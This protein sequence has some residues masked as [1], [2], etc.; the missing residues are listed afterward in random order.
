[1]NPKQDS[2]VRA[3]ATRY[4]AWAEAEL[5]RTEALVEFPEELDHSVHREDWRAEMDAHFARRKVW[6]DRPEVRAIR[7][8]REQLYSF[9]A[10]CRH[11]RKHPIARL[12]AQTRA[13]GRVEHGEYG[14]PDARFSW[15]W[16]DLSDDLIQRPASP[17]FGS[18]GLPDLRRQGRAWIDWYVRRTDTKPLKIKVE[19]STGRAVW[20][21]GASLRRSAG[22]SVTLHVALRPVASL[23]LTLRH[24]LPRVLEGRS[25][26]YSL[27]VFE[28]AVQWDLGKPGSGDEWHRDDPLNW[29]RGCRFW[30]D[31]VFGRATYT[32]E[33]IGAPV[34]A[35]A[36]FPEGQYTLTLQREV[37]TWKRPRWPW[38]FWRRSVD[39]TLE[40]PP[41]FQGKGE[42]SYDCG[43][44][45]IYGMS[46]SGHSFEQAVATYV[47]AVLKKRAKRGHLAPEHR[48]LLEAAP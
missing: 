10:F 16:Q 32:N 5:A 41:G 4:L 21:S 2:I 24:I 13:I 46:S 36:C 3:K 39:I 11:R 19:W 1:M 7:E 47:G 40:Q 33:K 30:L 28:G 35:V 17:S 48:T 8:Y 31:D 15:R 9:A 38:P 6:Q 42:N 18:L 29:M 45:A 27:S 44:D 14:E 43:P 25:K 37:T 12:L 23:Y 34:Q 22:G 26:A 20:M